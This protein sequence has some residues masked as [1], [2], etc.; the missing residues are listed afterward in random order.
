MLFFVAG[1]GNTQS[2][3]PVTQPR[4]LSLGWHHVVRECRMGR[5]KRERQNSSWVGERGRSGEVRVVRNRLTLMAQLVT[6]VQEYVWAW[7]ITKGQVLV[8]G[9]GTAEVACVDTCGSCCH[10]LVVWI[11]T[12]S[13]EGPGVKGP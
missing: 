6:R 5:W 3:T 1:F 2:S 11:T 7:A 13:H 10:E 9:P 12:W 8:Q 4:A